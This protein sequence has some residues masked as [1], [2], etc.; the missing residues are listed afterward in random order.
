M[1]IITAQIG[2]VFRLCF[3]PLFFPKVQGA[4]VEASFEMWID[5]RML[6]MSTRYT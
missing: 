6:L 2:P 5:A 4:S 1:M 3:V